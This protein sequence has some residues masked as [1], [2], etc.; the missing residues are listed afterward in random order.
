MVIRS[1]RETVEGLMAMDLEGN[2]VVDCYK[3]W[4]LIINIL[5]VVLVYE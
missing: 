3:L 5:C 2:E 4:R 1:S